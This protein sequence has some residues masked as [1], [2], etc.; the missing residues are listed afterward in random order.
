MGLTIASREWGVGGNMRHN[1]FKITF[2]SSYPTG[3]EPL[4]VAKMGLKTL[5][6][7]VIE[8]ASG[9]VFVYDRTNSKVKAYVTGASSGAVLAE[10]GDTTNMASVSTYVRAEGW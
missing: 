4:T 3:G 10:E 6:N 2:D 8:P 7:I 1:R 9:Y 5:S